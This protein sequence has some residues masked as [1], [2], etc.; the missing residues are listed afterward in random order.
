L[1]DVRRRVKLLFST[2]PLCLARTDSATSFLIGK[3]L[4]NNPFRI[5][6]V[7]L[8]NKLA[9]IVGSPDAKGSVSALPPNGLR[10][11]T[12]I[13]LATAVDDV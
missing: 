12:Q 10:K 13:E 6:S 5:V 2:H 8:A 3:V 9:R 7:P 11:A 4:Q 1:V